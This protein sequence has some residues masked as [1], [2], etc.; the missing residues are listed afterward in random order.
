[1]EVLEELNG[2]TLYDGPNSP[3][4]KFNIINLTLMWKYWADLYSRP[5]VR[6]FPSQ[7]KY[8]AWSNHA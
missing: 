7:E 5:S 3:K 8:L 6:I 1:M 4:V 2:Q